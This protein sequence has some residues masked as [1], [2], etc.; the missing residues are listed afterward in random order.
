MKV[1]FCDYKKINI[2]DDYPNGFTIRAEK[3]NKVIVI[4]ISYSD[5]ADMIDKM[6]RGF[7]RLKEEIKL[8]LWVD[9]GRKRFCENLRK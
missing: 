1:T 9:L 3:N 2:F 8:N 5:E 7:K 6:I 4:A